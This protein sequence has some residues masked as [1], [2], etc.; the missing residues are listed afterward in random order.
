MSEQW[1]LLWSQSQNAVHVE[2]L[3]DCLSKNRQ[4]YKDNRKTD[5]VPIFVGERAHVAAAAGHCSN[6]LLDRE[7]GLDERQTPE[8]A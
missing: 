6:T 1:V 7:L 8:A 2:S 4:A 5:Y 3:Q